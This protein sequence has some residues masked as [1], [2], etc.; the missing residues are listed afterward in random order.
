[1]YFFIITNSKQSKKKKNMKQ[2]VL[3]NVAH[4][5]GFLRIE[6]RCLLSCGVE[7]DVL[8]YRRWHTKGVLCRQQKKKKE[9]KEIYTS[10]FFMRDHIILRL[11]KEAIVPLFY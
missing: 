6:S 2:H 4:N 1:M 7:C 8:V 5:N 9:E 11:N 3:W 10:M